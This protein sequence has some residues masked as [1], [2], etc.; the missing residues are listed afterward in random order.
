MKKITISHTTIVKNEERVIGRC[1]DSIKDVID[2][3]V[4]VDT[5]SVDKTI[6]IVKDKA[7]KCYHTKWTGDYATAR[8]YGVER[9]TSDWI[10]VQDADEHMTSESVRTLKGIL[11]KV[12]EDI[13]EILCIV[14]DYQDES[15]IPIYRL[16][17]HRLFRNGKG[18][19]WAGKGH[20][21]LN[22]PFA[23]RSQDQRIVLMHDK[24]VNAVSP[25]APGPTD[26]AQVFI[27]NFLDSI[28]KNP[29][30]ARSMFYLSNTL[31]GQLKHKKA[32]EWYHKYLKTSSWK[33]ERYQARLFCSRC[34]TAIGE[35][36]KARSMMLNAYE[37]RTDRAEGDLLLGELAFNENKY[38]QALIWF[39]LGAKKAEK[40][41]KNEWPETLLFL[42]GKCYTYL[43]YDWLAIT[44]WKLGDKKNARK[45][46]KKALKIL[47]DN[48]R[49]KGNLE[50]YK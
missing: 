47:P 21:A 6:D 42:E 31:M 30:D 24:T 2:E 40:A 36:E 26:L 32:I 18:I 23:H 10:L 11:A 28:E 44:Y 4:I 1:I 19:K 7:G 25:I 50:Y 16:Y 15:M 38:N 39:H 34:Y 14:Q 48:A 35:Y 8:N 33:D 41:L 12:P 45:Y 22:T 17:G 37:E 49:L 29:K 27:K 13:W 46:T 3:F 9:C 5:G 20:E 43:P